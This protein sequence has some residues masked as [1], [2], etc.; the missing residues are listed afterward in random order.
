MP[1]VSTE[2]LG[3]CELASHINSG[4]D[5]GHLD[6]VWSV[7]GLDAR[8]NCSVLPGTPAAATL[9]ASADKGS[10]EFKASP[11]WVWPTAVAAITFGP[12]GP[13]QPAERM[14]R[15]GACNHAGTVRSRA[16]LPRC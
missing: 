10:K 13:S 5:R 6:V 4:D 15:N 1:P 8:V 16:R 7:G 2:A 14:G 3:C 12:V 9:L 11:S